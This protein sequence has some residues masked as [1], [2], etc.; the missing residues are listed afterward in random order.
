MLKSKVFCALADITVLRVLG[1]ELGSG[2]TSHYRREHVKSGRAKGQAWSA[3]TS[4]LIS[5]LQ[6]NTCVDKE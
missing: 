1:L 2:F 4:L 3:L 5:C 6:Q